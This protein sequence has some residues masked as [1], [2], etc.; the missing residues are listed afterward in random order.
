LSAAEGWIGLGNFAEAAAELDALPPA[1]QKNPDVL[2]ARW[3]IFTGAKNWPAGF[4]VGTTL[5]E[6]APDIPNGWLHS[7]YSLRRADTGGLQAAWDLLFPALE[8]FPTC[9]MIAY[10]L[11][12]YACQLNRMDEAQ[13]LLKRAMATDHKNTFKD[14]ALNDAD[15]EPLRA[16]IL[17]M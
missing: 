4:N 15:L 14:M 1:L 13:S 7:A 16:E 17:K 10:N 6:V 8:K 12:C 3:F 2:D 9:G 11:A 5:I